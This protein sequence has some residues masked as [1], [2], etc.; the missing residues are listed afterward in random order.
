MLVVAS[1]S[2]SGGIPRG[3]TMVGDAR[4]YRGG[5]ATMPANP[6]LE[7]VQPEETPRSNF[8]SNFLSSSVLDLKFE[9]IRSLAYCCSCGAPSSA[10]TMP[11]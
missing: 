3:Q 1:V 8:L 11:W 2:A 6:S 9:E 7:P 10:M 5:S 4:R